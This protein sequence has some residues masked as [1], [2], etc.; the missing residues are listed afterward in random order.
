MMPVLAMPADSIASALINTRRVDGLA[1]GFNDFFVHNESPDRAAF[2]AAVTLIP[3]L[4]VSDI[5]KAIFEPTPENLFK[6]YM[7]GSVSQ[8]ESINDCNV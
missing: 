1:V 6:T 5:E 4:S 2:D 7:F 8:V 3:R